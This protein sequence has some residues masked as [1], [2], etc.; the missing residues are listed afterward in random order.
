MRRQRYL[1]TRE[2]E[3]RKEAH[4]SR[5]CFRKRDDLKNPTNFVK[6]AKEANKG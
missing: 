6:K 4:Q 3:G 1:E 2:K 5:C